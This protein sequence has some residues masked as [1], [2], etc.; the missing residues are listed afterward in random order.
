IVPGAPIRYR[1]DEAEIFLPILVMADPLEETRNPWDNVDDVGVGEG[2]VEWMVEAWVVQV[3]E[4]RS[5]VGVEEDEVVLVGEEEE[6]SGGDEG[7]D[8]GVENRYSPFT[9]K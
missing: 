8:G 3:A 5:E 9:G 7:G 6:A 2:F 4:E 1:G